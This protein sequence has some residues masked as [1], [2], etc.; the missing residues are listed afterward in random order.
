MSERHAASFE[1]K[2]KEH[3]LAL[4]RDA[5]ERKLAEQSEQ[6]LA[7]ER[8]RLELDAELRAK[9]IQLQARKIRED[10]MQRAMRMISSGDPFLVEKGK[11]LYEKLEKEEEKE[12]RLI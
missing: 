8:Q 2:R 5:R 12:A 11:E 1:L 3:E 4:A 6:H 9:E 10:Q 7:L